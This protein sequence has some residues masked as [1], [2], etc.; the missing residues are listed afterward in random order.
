MCQIN[1]NT[2]ETKKKHITA[3]E[4]LIIEHLFNIQKLKRYEIAKELGKHKST[5]GREIKLGLIVI[6]HYAYDMPKSVYSAKIAQDKHD[7]NATAKGPNLKIS[8]DYQLVDFIDS[9][10]K[11]NKSPEVISNLIKQS[12]QFD[13]TLSTNTIYS[14][15]DNAIIDSTRDNLVFGNYKARKGIR[16]K[17]NVIRKRNKTGRTIHDRPVEAD[18]KESGHWE[19]DTV[20][21]VKGADEPVLL[22]LTERA[23]N[24]EIIELIDGKTQDAVEKAL[25]RIE[26]EFG[27][28]N[29]RETFK[30][31]TSDNGSEFLNF[32]SVEK[33]VVNKK[34]PRTALYY[35]DA[36]CS[37]QRGAN[38][39]ANRFIRR[40]LP[41]GTSFKHLT[42]QTVKLIEKWMNDYPRKKFGFL[43]PNEVYRKTVF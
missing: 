36:Y 29:F 34:L 12:D 37:W 13:T 10:I 2:K 43:T 8:N 28:K 15:V 18:N 35:A 21:G 9:H 26:R 31:I 1:D 6:D 32:S 39:N 30:S 7:F 24:K 5:I 41:K 3:S 27:A 14:Y 19:M 25:N 4:R 40:F 38:E 16:K 22:V 11:D 23:S 20:E 42:R 33:S 17:E